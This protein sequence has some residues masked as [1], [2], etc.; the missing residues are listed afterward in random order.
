MSYFSGVLATAFSTLMLT[1]TFA[2]A[3]SPAKVF[4]DADAIA[5]S[6]KYDMMCN[7]FD[8]QE[9]ERYVEKIEN[10]YKFNYEEATAPARKVV[11]FIVSCT[12]GAY[13]SNSVLLR[14]NEY[15][16]KLNAVS[17]ATPRT[18]AKG[19]VTGWVADVVQ[20]GLSYDSTTREL[21]SWAKGR[22]I[23]DM[24]V[25]GTYELY[26]A[27]VVLRKYFIDS[28]EGEGEAPGLVY[29]SKLPLAY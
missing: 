25:V 1:S 18:N 12:A 13:N 21:T 26:E 7:D 3:A 9:A 11:Y 4:T 8:N 16:G 15:E 29:E 10:E 28:E 27:D 6:K 19:E 17:L 5:E 14:V 23:G 2:F 22:G 24:Y 20:P